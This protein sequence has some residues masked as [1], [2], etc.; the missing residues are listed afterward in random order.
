MPPAPPPAGRPAARCPP[1]ARSAAAPPARPPASGWGRCCAAAAGRVQERVGGGRGGC[2]ERAGATGWALWD[3][4]VPAQQSRTGANALQAQ[5]QQRSGRAKGGERAWP[6]LVHRTCRSSAEARGA[7]RSSPSSGQPTADSCARIYRRG[8]ECRWVQP[9]RANVVGSDRNVQHATSSCRQAGHSE[10]SQYVA[11]QRGQLCAAVSAERRQG[12]QDAIA[13][14]NQHRGQAST[15][16]MQQQVLW[17]AGG[18][19]SERRVPGRAS[20]QP[21][22]PSGMRST[23]TPHP[24][25]ATLFLPLLEHMHTW[26]VLPV[27]SSNRHSCAVGPQRSAASPAS[28]T[29]LTSNTCSSQG[30]LSSV[31]ASCARVWKGSNACRF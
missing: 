11:L 21:L 19:E 29:S 25:S 10:R 2:M 12:M 30:A 18:L 8:G 27:M 23:Y 6:G 4:P 26:C 24:T 9:A 15:C 22:P 14:G 16:K 7:Y 1:L 31:G 28:S 5:P 3:T 20:P 17:N 13:G